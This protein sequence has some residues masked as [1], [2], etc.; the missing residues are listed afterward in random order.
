MA[1]M[2]VY[3]HSLSGQFV[4]EDT[5][6]A[7]QLTLTPSRLLTRAVSVVRSAVIGDSSSA[8]RSVS[9]GL[10]LLNGALLLLL[11]RSVVPAGAAVA[12]MGLFLLLPLNT[13]AVGYA[14]N[15]SELLMALCAL[16]AV[17][18]ADKRR[19]VL[20]WLACACAVLAKEPGI[21]AF[22]LVPLWMGGRGRWDRWQLGLW[23]ASVAMPA[24]SIWPMVASHGYGV[25]PLYDLG[26]NLTAYGWLLTKFALPVGL[27]PMPDWYWLSPLSV[28]ACVV[29]LAGLMERAG[30][31]PQAR[32]VALLVLAS[33]APRLLWWLPGGPREH[34]LYLA[35][36]V[37]S[38]A[39]MG[40]LWGADTRFRPK[41]LHDHAL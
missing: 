33:L 38:V 14:A 26:R 20:A 18:L 15:Q 23:L 10:H 31:H 3:A 24:L 6:I 35:A 19:P 11:A 29:L 37:L 22:L 41:G 34:H 16:S 4:Y 1:T 8:Q 28:S 21:C 7:P 9:L 17:L 27:T 30:R 2:A 25:P 13:E 39:V 36:M 32:F 40:W 5:R 12:A